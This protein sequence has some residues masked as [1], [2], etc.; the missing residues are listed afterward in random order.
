MCVC[1]CVCVRQFLYHKFP[2]IYKGFFCSFVYDR[3]PRKA[4]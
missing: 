4:T 2:Y 3:T 1:V